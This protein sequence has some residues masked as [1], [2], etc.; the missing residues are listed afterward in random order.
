MP[1]ERVFGL[2][3]SLES[4]YYILIQVKTTEKK[5]ELFIRF[6]LALSFLAI[7]LSNVELINVKITVLR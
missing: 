2:K 5:Q 7:S 4:S 6:F 1:F 3:D